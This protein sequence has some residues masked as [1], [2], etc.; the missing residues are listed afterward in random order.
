MSMSNHTVVSNNALFCI[1]TIPCKLC[2][3]QEHQYKAE[4][5]TYGLTEIGTTLTKGV[6][7]ASE[8]WSGGMRENFEM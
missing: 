6:T 5:R 7:F 4:C 8:G 1:S 3:T 2:K